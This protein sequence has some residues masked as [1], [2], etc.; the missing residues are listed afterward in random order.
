MVCPPVS[1]P[2]KKIPSGDMTSAA[3]KHSTSTTAIT[4]P[5]PVASGA[6]AVRMA[7]TA[8]RRVDAVALTTGLSTVATVRIAPPAASTA[9]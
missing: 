3:T 9:R 8:P 6:M 5:P 7:D 1:S 4:A 2:P